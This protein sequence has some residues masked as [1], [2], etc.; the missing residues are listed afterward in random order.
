MAEID[1]VDTGAI[2]KTGP[3]GWV[4]TPVSST[5]S[6]EPLTCGRPV[7]DESPKVTVC[8]PFSDVIDTGICSMPKKLASSGPNAAGG[9]PNEPLTTAPIASTCSGE[10][11]SSTIT[12]TFHPPSDIS[13]GES[14]ISTKVC[15]ETST[16]S[17]SP[18]SIVNARV[19]LHRS[20]VAGNCIFDQVHGHVAVHEQFS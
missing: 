14:T 8:S 7:Y 18:S 4:S 2:P 17:M 19:A 11:P 5:T 6:P 9:P 16:P 1:E 20:V 13:G 3:A 12:P 15:P 10:A